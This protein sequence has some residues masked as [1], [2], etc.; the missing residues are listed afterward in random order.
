M[1][2]ELAVKSNA[3]EKLYAS[4]KSKDF[5]INVLKQEKE[6]LRQEK[7]G[8][9]QEKEGLRHEREGL[10]MRSGGLEQQKETLERKLCAFFFHF[11][12]R[13]MNL[14]CNNEDNF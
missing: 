7:E 4:N 1:L 13:F 2:D 8:L 9:R 10:C 5:L 11:R 14:L 12:P 6:D 3:L